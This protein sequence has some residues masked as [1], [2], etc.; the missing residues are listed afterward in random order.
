MFFESET[1]EN[2]SFPSYIDSLSK[3]QLNPLNLCQQSSETPLKESLECEKSPLNEDNH[4][5]NP[6]LLD[7]L[8]E[9]QYENFS[10]ALKK[11]ASSL[12]STN[13]LAI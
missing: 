3:C 5:I 13:F 7:P 9:K 6:E 8:T 12:P 4:S 11:A 2:S 10:Q 1:V